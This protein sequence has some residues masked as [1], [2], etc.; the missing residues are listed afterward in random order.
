MKKI[1][2]FLAIFMIGADTIAAGG[3]GGGPLPTIIPMQ[4]G[5]ITSLNIGKIRRIGGQAGAA[6]IIWS[7]SSRSYF[8][9]NY[10]PVDGQVKA[11]EV[12]A[13]L[14][15]Q[16]MSFELARPEEDNVTLWSFIYDKNWNTLFYGVTSSK[17]EPH[18]SGEWRI[19]AGANKMKLQ[20]V[21]EYHTVE[22]LTGVYF[23]ERNDAGNII[24]YH[25]IEVIGN[26]V[27]SSRF[28]FPEWL[29]D[30]RGELYLRLW[31]S[32]SG[33][34]VVVYDSATGERI[35]PSSV[36]AT[37]DASFEGLQSIVP[38]GDLV[39][40]QPVV[41]IGGIG[42]S[43][44]I[45]VT[46]TFPGWYRV[47]HQTTEGEIFD[48]VIVWRVGSPTETEYDRSTP[49]VPVQLEPGVYHLR[50]K[51]PNLKSPNQGGGGGGPK[52]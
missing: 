34:V 5:Q 14:G 36:V 46:V 6:Y 10:D 18:G 40:P 8:D 4:S 30:R 49:A 17:L 3:G 19:P 33:S 47:S 50:F 43:D 45:E 48:S 11:S 27:W 2:A 35:V 15:S 42:E 51:W 38:Q 22:K 52:G 29:Q 32:T 20:A 16:V 31:D 39:V 44:L 24:N 25:D 12:L 1:I 41:S 7:S 23:V 26:D 37:I 9:V 28:Q 21:G 13:L